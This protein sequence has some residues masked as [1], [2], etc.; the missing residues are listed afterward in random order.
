MNSDGLCQCYLCTYLRAER[1][2]VELRSRRTII[3]RGVLGEA[4]CSLLAHVATRDGVILPA[5]PEQE[6]G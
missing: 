4:A 2:R 6:T 1:E 3:R 5:E